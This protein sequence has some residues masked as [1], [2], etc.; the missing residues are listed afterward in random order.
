MRSITIKDLAKSLGISKSTVSRA[1][2]GD[3]KNVSDETIR[4]VNEAAVSM[5]YRKNE[6]AANLRNR[7]SKAIG[8]IIPETVTSFYLRFTATVQRILH[9]YGYRII[10]ALSDEDYNTE[11][12]NIET[13]KTYNLDGILISTCHN[14]ANRDFYNDLINKGFPMVFFDRTITGMDCSSVRS[15][16]YRSAFFL[17]EHLIY[18]GHRKILHLAG[19]DYIANSDERL[20][21]YTDVLAKHG[22]KY[23]PELVVKAGVDEIAGVEAMN[24]ILNSDLDYNA[25][26]C[27][28]ELQAIGAKKVLQERGVRIPEDVAIICMS[29]TKLSTL[30]YPE[31]TAVEQ[32]LEKMAEEAVRLL[33]A[34]IDNPAAPVEKVVLHADMVIRSSSETE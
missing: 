6:M 20:R 5:G 14:K 2:S 23:C 27:F 4:K 21:A 12:F 11:R 19:P 8:L 33:L 26:F 3:S 17:I 28:T 32:P 30:V 22:I 9:P 7:K 24:K 31:I 16:D 34:K 18:N 10:L 29:G 25:L 13:F 1:L 15:D